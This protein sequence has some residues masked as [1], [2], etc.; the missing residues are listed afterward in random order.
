MEEKEYLELLDQAYSE[1]PQVL[2]KKE[3]FE[4]PKVSGRLIKSR[5][6]INNFREIAKH[7]SRDEDHFFKFMLKEVGVRGEIGNRGDMILHSR[8]QPAMLNKAV[9]TY[10]ERFVKCPHCTSPDTEFMNDGTILK[11]KACGHQEKISKV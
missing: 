8:F 4:I 9:E 7:F 2:Y 10:F 6:V 5:T 1:L 11:C 3:R